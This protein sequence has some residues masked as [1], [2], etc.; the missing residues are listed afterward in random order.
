MGSPARPGRPGA[1][2]EREVEEKEASSCAESGPRVAKFDAV[3]KK[4]GGGEVKGTG[5]V[6]RDA[7]ISLDVRLFFPNMQSVPGYSLLA[8]SN[9]TASFLASKRTPSHL[10]VKL[11]AGPPPRDE[12]LSVGPGVGKRQAL[13]RLDGQRASR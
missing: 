11:V 6:H 9:P 13:R 8:F 1:G 4:G 5:Y 2:S 3:Y 12:E 10:R 7:R